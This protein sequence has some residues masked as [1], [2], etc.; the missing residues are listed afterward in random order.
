MLRHLWQFAGFVAALSAGLLLVSC[1]GVGAAPINAVPLA[2]VSVA[3]T[4]AAMNVGT[5]TVEPFLAV[6]NGSGLQTV[7]WRVNGIPGGA[8]IIGT[9][10]NDGNYTA[11][12]FIPNPPTVT[13]TAA[14]NADNTKSGNAQVTITGTQFPAKVYMSPIGTAY[15]QAGTAMK[16][17][18][19]II[20][21][22]DTAVVWQVN[23]IPNG[24]TTVGTITP[25]ANNTAIYTAPAR[26]PNPANVTIKAIAH[27]DATKFSS[28]IVTLSAQPPTIA[29]VTITPVVAVGQSETNF[30][31]T[32]DVINASDNT[33]F[34][35][36]NGNIGGDQTNGGIASEGPDTGIYTGPAVVPLDSSVTVT[37][38]SVVQPSRASSAIMTISPPAANGVSVAVGGGLS[39]PTNSSE[40]VTATVSAPGRSTESSVGTPPMA[41]FS[42]LRE[43]PATRRIISLPTMFHRRTR[44]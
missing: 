44:W 41:Q 23:G 10:D 1:G 15:V 2:A 24:N 5:G 30:T 29:T 3:I 6:V 26:V 36:V 19:G 8:P 14:A 38:V 20:G 37:A 7:Q 16:L 35:E 13:L 27:A 12:Q 4:P 40:Q 34:W 9:I 31:F 17:S 28:C 32:A 33:V 39:L 42:R 18:G 21:P 11:P 25:G 22:F 43:V